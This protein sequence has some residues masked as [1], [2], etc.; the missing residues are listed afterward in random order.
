MSSEAVLAVPLSRPKIHRFPAASGRVPLAYP[1]AGRRFFLLFALALAAA[2]IVR[3]VSG[4]MKDG[5]TAA[6]H[7]PHAQAAAPQKAVKS[8]IV[9]N[10]GDSG[11]II[12]QMAKIPLESEHITEVKPASDV[13][14]RAGRELFSII[15][16]Y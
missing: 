16:K 12:G 13:D 5:E 8:T 6:A 11:T 4:P 14:K 2:L 15:S 7:S 9:I 10:G 3:S 1:P